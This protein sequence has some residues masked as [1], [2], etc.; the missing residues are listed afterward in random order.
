MVLGFLFKK[1]T[2][3]KATLKKEKNIQKIG[4][5]THY[6]PKVK[7]AVIKITKGPLKLGDT[8]YIKGYSTDFKQKIASMQIERRPIK[9]AKKGNIIGLRVRKR[10]R[11]GDTA[12]KEF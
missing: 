3:K 1:K 10:T 8:L 9:L 11:E 12:F 7:A 2:T 4:T 6:F 5:V